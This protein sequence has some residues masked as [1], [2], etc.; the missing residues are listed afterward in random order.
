M[1]P[2]PKLKT[3]SGIFW[4]LL[5]DYSLYEKT[6]PGNFVYLFICEV[7]T[8]KVNFRFYK[9][10]SQAA[11]RL[12][13]EQVVLCKISFDSFNIPLYIE[14]NHVARFWKWNLKRT[15]QSVQNSF[16][17][18]LNLKFLIIFNMISFAYTQGLV[19]IRLAYSKVLL[20][21]NYLMVA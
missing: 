16:W 18:K 3:Y 20:V 17:G 11:T 19:K 2:F 14:R 4:V 10:C 12:I 7:T 8:T 9:W 21:I 5:I 13:C 1:V 6:I 15:F